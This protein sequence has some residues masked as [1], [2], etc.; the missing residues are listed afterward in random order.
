[1]DREEVVPR[2]RKPNTYYPS[3]QIFLL[4]EV[5]DGMTWWMIQADKQLF[6]AK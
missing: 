3:V 2:P 5:R 1:M 4:F 6:P